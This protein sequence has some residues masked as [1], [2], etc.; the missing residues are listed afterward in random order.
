MSAEEFN[1]DERVLCSD[2]TCIGLVGPDGRCRECGALYTG[3]ESLPQNI[4]DIS[5]EETPKADTDP[6]ETASEPSEPEGTYDS[7]EERVCCSDETCV[8]IIGP[9]GVCGTCGKL[10]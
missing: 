3:S 4:G 2:D 5:P 9:D 1:L 8:G 10:A 6:G 7:D